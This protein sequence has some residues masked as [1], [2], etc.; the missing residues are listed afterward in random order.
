[1]IRER[2]LR[3]EYPLLAGLFSNSSTQA[4]SLIT[5]F[6]LVRALFT[7]LFAM[8]MCEETP[9]LSL[10][11]ATVPPLPLDGKWCQEGHPSLD[12]EGASP[13]TS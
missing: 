1:M 5:A 11:N 12:G 9:C 3:R 2:A 13:P 8:V 4:T 10:L 6:F 7:S